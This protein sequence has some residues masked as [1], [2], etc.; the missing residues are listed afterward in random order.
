MPGPALHHLIASRL[1]AHI[2]QNEGLG[3]HMSA[4]E[5]AQI[6]ALLADP[7]NLPY[8]FLGCQG[9]DFLFFNTKDMNP[10]LGK[11]VEIYMEV[12]DFIENFKRELLKIVPQ[13][14]LDALAAFDEAVDEVIED[15][16][17]LSEL[18]QTFDDIN[19]LLDSLLPT[20][21]EMV[22]KF[23]SE[24]NL[25]DLIS[26]PYRDGTSDGN[27]WWFDALHYRKTGKYAKALL[28][29]SDT[30]KPEHLYAMGYLTHV[31]ADTVGHPYVN[32]VS[33][34]PYRSQAQRH[35]TGENYQDV[36]NFL[37]QT[38]Q[39]FNR[40]KLHAFYNFNFNGTISDS[41]P[42]AFTNLPD[43]LARLIADT[44][45]EI[46]RSNEAGG[47]KYGPEI[48]PTDINNAYRIYYKWF[49][50]ST[51]TG[52]LPLPVPYSLTAELR[53]VWEKTIDNLGDAGDF[54]E[55]A[56]DEAGD[57]G[58]LSIFIIL[59]ALI[60]AAVMAA[61]ALADGIAGAIATLGTSTIRYAAC[62]IY[63]QVYNAFQNFRLGTALNGLAFPMQEHLTEPRL[64]QFANPA[65]PDPTGARAID[66]ISK[67]PMFR[68]ITDFGGDPSAAI[69]N[70]ERHLIYPP[71]G[72]E[73]KPVL[74]AP[75]EY[76]DKFSTH[77]AFGDILINNNFI[78][79]LVNMSDDN[80]AMNND[81]GDELET[82]LINRKNR[83][84]NA[85]MLTE[86]LYNRW[87]ADKPIPDFNLDGDR[88]YAYMCWSQENKTTP[89]TIEDSD[90]P[91]ELRAKDDPA[92]P[93]DQDEIVQ[94][95]FIQ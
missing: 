78:D 52:T 90:S 42:D 56:V 77:F 59:A 94:L 17:L 7:K 43:D 67:L 20:L 63:E 13:P 69:F 19:K 15:S 54:L 48:T 72:G 50:N 8:L 33:G 38:G 93:T 45:S 39:D 22:K 92:N 55:N 79:E 65:V 32:I 47:E 71:T 16:A 60:I 14:V 5:Y 1:R 91:Q 34:G 24:F 85:L 37:T 86:N 66:F 57:W 6:Q 27:W 44:I 46:Y 51:D 2:S 82:K 25:F 81:N 12:T 31:T 73:K 9:P 89:P 10:T 58:I 35:K 84:G 3:A 40:S 75:H 68:F 21:T 87:K 4:A 23:I 76:F 61:A 41:E 83:L 88:G 29:N 70:Q 49:R 64:I 74:E 26:H 11:F 28:N 80:N 30:G 95:R 62:L 18:K 53:E 36:F